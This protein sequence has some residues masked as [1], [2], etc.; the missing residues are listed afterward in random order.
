MNELVTHY[1]K[2]NNFENNFKTGYFYTTM[3]KLW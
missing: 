3:L 2:N 1:Q